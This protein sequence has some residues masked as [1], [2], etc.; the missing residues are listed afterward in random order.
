MDNDLHFTA[1]ADD[2]DA[3]SLDMSDSKSFI[4]TEEDLDP[5]DEEQMLVYDSEK[6]FVKPGEKSPAKKSTRFNHYTFPAKMMEALC[7]KR[8]DATLALLLHLTRIWFRDFQRNPIVLSRAEI[9]GVKMTRNQKARA[10]AILEESGFVSVEQ[11]PGRSPLVT[12]NWKPL[13]E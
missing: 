10:L 7:A 1:V 5:R 4:V 9:D 8:Q 11:R 12:L 6:G 3:G 13:K 2:Q